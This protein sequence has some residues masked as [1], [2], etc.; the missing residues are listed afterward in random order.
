MDNL[1]NSS[2]VVTTDG[3]CI[4][5]TNQ[6]KGTDIGQIIFVYNVCSFQICRGFYK[7]WSNLC[8]SKVFES[9]IKEDWFEIN[10]K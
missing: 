6:K 1:G 9:K 4:F 5:D 8:G 10:V 2:H 7:V 3:V